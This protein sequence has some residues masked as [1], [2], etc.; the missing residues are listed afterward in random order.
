MTVADYSGVR[1][2]VAGLRRLRRDGQPG[3][4][5]DARWSTHRPVRGWCRTG[6][7]SPRRPPAS[8]C[9][10]SVT[11]RQRPVRHRVRPRL[12]LAGRLE[13]RGADRAV[14]R[15]GGHCRR[16][17]RHRDDVVD[18]PAHRRAEPGADG[19]VHLHLRQRGVRLRRHRLERPGRRRG[20][21]RVGLRRRWHGD[22][23]DPEP[24]LRDLGH[25]R[26]HLDRDRRRGHDRAR[27]SSRSRSSAPTPT[28]RRRSR[29]AARSSSA[30]STRQPRA[31]A[32]A[33]SRRTRGTSATARPTPR[34]V[35]RRATP[36]D[37]AGTYV[38]TLTVTDNDGGTGARRATRAGGGASD[39]TRGQ[40]RQPGQRVDAEHRRPRG[41]G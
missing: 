2:G 23:R 14:R 20:L 15:P 18:R 29:R 6:P 17:Q 4:A 1:T 19:G 32:T 33:P 8:R 13:R 12:Q 24:R 27:S 36:I 7:T 35:R 34:P 5:R 22:R 26:R 21:L 41:D 38:V 3:R 39:R 30:A 16:R 10:A 31:T 40:Q 37:A 9:P 28:R 11:G 25:P